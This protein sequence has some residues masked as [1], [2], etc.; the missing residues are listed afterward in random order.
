MER[1]GSGR[2]PL[3]DSA[4]TPRIYSKLAERVASRRF[5]AKIAAAQF[6]TQ[7]PCEFAPNP[8]GRH[9]PRRETPNPA[10]GKYAKIDLET[11]HVQTSVRELAA[12]ETINWFPESCHPLLSAQHNERIARGGAQRQT[13]RRS[14]PRLP[15]A[16]CCRSLGRDKRLASDRNS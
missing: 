2:V 9:T 13:I 11:I 8:A 14:H 1:R 12:Y 16:T 7:V 3:S 10:S 5:S 15:E 4:I 6:L